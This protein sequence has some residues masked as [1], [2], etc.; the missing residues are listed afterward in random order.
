MKKLLFIFAL[1]VSLVL[2]GAGFVYAAEYPDTLP[3]VPEKYQDSPYII[4]TYK[5]KP[6]LDIFYC[7]NSEFTCIFQVYK[8]QKLFRSIGSEGFTLVMY[9]LVDGSWG[10]FNSSSYYSSTTCNRSIDIPS[11]LDYSDIILYSTENVLDFESGKVVFPLPPGPLG[12]PEGTLEQIVTQE[13]PLKEILILL[14]MVIVCWAG[15]VGL[16]KALAILARILRKA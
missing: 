10:N 13:N 11:D 4:Y 6:Y 1:V 7:G 2:P 9:D 3:P 5:G 15:Y 12:M 16:R 8:S 14:P